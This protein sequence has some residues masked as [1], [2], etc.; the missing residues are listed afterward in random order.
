MMFG[1]RNVGAIIGDVDYA[2]VARGFGCYGRRVEKA[3]DIEPAFK[4]AR[5]SG[6]P[7]VLDVVVDPDTF[8]EQLASF[9]LG[10]FD[11]VSINATRAL[12]MPKMKLDRRLL[13]RA[14]YVI[15]ILLDKDLA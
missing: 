12:G 14:K 1:G 7:A 3:A 4:E 13:N 6:L 5:E 9:A 10:D 2:A 8:P 15:N 11:G